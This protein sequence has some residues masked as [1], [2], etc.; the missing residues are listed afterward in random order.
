MEPDRLLEPDRTHLLRAQGD[1]HVNGALHIVDAVGAVVGDVDADL[2][3]DLDG[4]RPHV[5]RHRAGR[6]DLHRNRSAIG[7]RTQGK[8]PGE[9]KG[10]EAHSAAVIGDTVGD[11]FKDTSG[12]SLNILIKLMSIVSLVIIPFLYTMGRL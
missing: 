10:G 11:P 8:I 6:R 9:A 5:G 1:H 3:K 4:L 7:P 12:P 2:A